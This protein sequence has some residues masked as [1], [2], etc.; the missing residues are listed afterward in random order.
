MVKEIYIDNSAT[1]KP[2]KEVIDIMATISLKDYANPSSLHIM[3]IEAEKHIKMTREII[4]ESLKVKPKEILFTSTGTESNN[5]AIIGAALANKRRGNHL[6]TSV[7]EHPSVL[8]TFKFLEDS[9]FDVSYIPVNKEGIVNIEE[10]KSAIKDETIL[11]SLMHVNNEIGSIQPIEKVRDILNEKKSKALYHVDAV[12][13]YG[14]LIFNIRNLSIDLLSISSHKIHGPKGIG[15]LYVKEGTLINPIIF[16]GNQEFGMRSGTE[17]TSGIVGFGKAV[18][19]NFQSLKTNI[20]KIESLKNGFKKEIIN[21]IEDTYINGLSN[22]NTAP[23]ILNISFPGIKSEVLL[24]ALEDKKIYVSTGS[25]CSS[26]RTRHSHV[27]SA[28]GIPI[29]QIESAIRFSFSIL[30]KEEEIKYVIEQL[31]IIVQDLRKY[32]RR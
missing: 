5:I 7:I 25:A 10:L 1:T 31:K 12:Q 19:I 21:N 9:G 3:G 2:H 8:N 13:S 27:L 17:N 26:G 4:A 15:A 14:K 24:H 28:L 11:I 18:E 23:H 6:I 16:G 32:T 30:N 22:E 20:K 29:D